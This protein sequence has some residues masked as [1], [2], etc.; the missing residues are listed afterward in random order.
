MATVTGLTKERMEQIE[1]Q[2]IVDGAVILGDLHLTRQDGTT[3]NAGR[4]QGEKGDS[5]NS[6]YLPVANTAPLR[7]S[8]G[9]IKAGE[10]IELNDV[11]TMN[12][13][14]SRVIGEELG[15]NVNLNTV[16]QPGIYTQSESAQTSTTLNYPQAN[17]GML[18]VFSNLRMPINS[19]NMIWQRYWPYGPFGDLFWQRAYYNGT[20]EKWTRFNGEDTGWVTTGLTITT[21]ASWS[22]NSYLLRRQG[23]HVHGTVVVTYN[24]ATITSDAGANFGDMNGIFVLPTGWRKTNN[25]HYT[26]PLVRQGITP[27][28]GRYAGTA[29]SVDF[30]NG[31]YDGQTLV[32]GYQLTATL[33]YFID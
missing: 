13:V 8:N 32:A 21:H 23:S 33:D 5:A 9:E 10:P 18:E 15:A 16:T 3:F 22:L 27:Y 30:T 20:W 24:G 29:G 31:T 14:D 7:G 28:V 2:C 17:A 4:V 1:A 11:A 26:V 25:M 12:Y 6:S 19:G